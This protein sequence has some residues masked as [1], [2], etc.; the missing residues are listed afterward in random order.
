MR[1]LAQVLAHVYDAEIEIGKGP[2]PRGTV[3][4]YER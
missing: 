3:R 2:E 4:F 1:D